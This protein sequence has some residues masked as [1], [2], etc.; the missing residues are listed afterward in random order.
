MVHALRASQSVL[1]AHHPNAPNS[2]IV[3]VPRV[4]INY[5]FLNRSSDEEDDDECRPGDSTCFLWCDFQG[6][7]AL[8]SKGNPNGEQNWTVPSF[9]N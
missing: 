6:P 8:A 4:C 1:R 2:D 7:Y 9:P 3:E 5:A